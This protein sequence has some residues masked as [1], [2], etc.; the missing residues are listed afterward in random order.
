[1]K[2]EILNVAI[3]GCGAIAERRHAPACHG[4]PGVRIA[5]FCDVA[6][7]RALRLAERYQAKAY[8]DLDQMLAEEALDAVCVC[9][10]E[11]FHCDM[12]LK[13][14]AAGTHVLCEK[15]MA[16]NMEDAK[17]MHRAGLAAGKLLMV[18]FSQRAY[19][20]HRLLKKLLKEGH[21]G[22]PIFFR[23]VLSHSGA[24]YTSLGKAE[25]FYDRN[26]KNIGGVMSSVGC[27]RVDLISWLFES[28]VTAVQAFTTTI[29]KKYSDGSPIDEEDTAEIH[30]RMENGLAGELFVS[31]CNYGPAGTA[32]EIY[33]S[34]GMMILDDDGYV[35][36]WKDGV[37][38]VYP[39]Q[40]DDAGKKGYG[41]VENFLKAC[42]G[43]E[44]PLA[45]SLDG[46]RCMQALEAVRRSGETGAWVFV[47]EEKGEKAWADIS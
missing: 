22:T 7:D 24:E 46:L 20:G 5:A 19:T 41:I 3:A 17:R 14:L 43:S 39:A 45:D 16:L 28:P 1:M 15:P 42:Q 29:D 25:D 32:T 36:V 33:G 23:S 30:V 11:R 12:V 21:I 2:K 10:P 6:A 4:T 31:W 40:M 34:D 18:A 13:C 27:H 9:S 47:S 37:C 44:K 35:R 26:L 38:T 8:A